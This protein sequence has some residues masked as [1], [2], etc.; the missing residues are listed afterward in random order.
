MYALL[1]KY[2][3]PPRT[4]SHLAEFAVPTFEEPFDI[5]VTT[6]TDRFTPTVLYKCRC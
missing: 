4:D 5:T 3:H 1:S 2:C 6:K